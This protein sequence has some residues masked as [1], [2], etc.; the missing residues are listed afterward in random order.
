M[1]LANAATTLDTYTAAILSVAERRMDPTQR[2]NPWVALPPDVPRPP[3]A[4]ISTTYPW[5]MR[6]WMQF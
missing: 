4:T 6:P 1:M 2:R 3:I 5:A